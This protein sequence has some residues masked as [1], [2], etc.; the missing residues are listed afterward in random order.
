MKFKKR[1]AALGGV[2]VTAGYVYRK[3]IG[4]FLV[5][6]ACDVLAFVSKFSDIKADV[7]DGM[8][9]GAYQHSMMPPWV[10]QLVAEGTL[11][12][13]DELIDVSAY[14]APATFERIAST[15]IPEARIKHLKDHSRIVSELADRRDAALHQEDKSDYIDYLRELP[16]WALK[17]IAL[18]W[19]L[20][21]DV[22]WKAVSSEDGK[23][24][25]LQLL[26]DRL[27][28]QHMEDQAYE[29]GG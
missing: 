5:D 29:A 15:L 22:V 18:R 21:K 27:H 2:L 19:K 7:D 8:S 17:K 11:G 3:D 6:R 16:L 24:A 1:Y 12:P 4:Y 25:T 13:H 23:Q 14:C 28:A 9:N 20:D 10:E 26:I